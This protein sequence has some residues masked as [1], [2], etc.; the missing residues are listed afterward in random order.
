MSSFHIRD[1]TIATSGASDA[2]TGISIMQSGPS[3][4]PALG[5]QSDF[6]NV[7][8][9]G[10]DGYGGTDYWGAGITINSA[11]LINFEGINSPG[12]ASKSGIGVEIVGTGNCTTTPGC[13]VVF[14]FHSSAFNFGNNGVLIGTNVQGVTFDQCNFTGGNYGIV[15]A[16]SALYLDQL[17]VSNSQFNAAVH[18]ILIQSPFGDVAIA[19]NLFIVA[20][21]GEGVVG[22]MNAFTIH[23]NTF[24]GQLSTSQGVEV[25]HT[26]TNG[27]ITGNT[28]LNLNYG[29]NVDN[30][31]DKVNVQ[32]NL[33]NGNTNNTAPTSTTGSVT[34]G[35]GTP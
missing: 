10:S 3:L 29:V 7:T 27:V 23:G 1:I 9:R 18:N 32:S 31:A 15:V 24:E 34:I 12:N 6:T 35:G 22:H 11:S 26:S 33:Y 17:A 16:S 21:E 28:F 14:N 5:A 8:L 4:N 20:P 30:T 2:T 25:Q 13:A 19:D